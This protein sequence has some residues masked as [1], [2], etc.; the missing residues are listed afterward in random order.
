VLRDKTHSTSFRHTQRRHQQQKG[1]LVFTDIDKHAHTFFRLTRP[2]GDEH[3]HT[4]SRNHT[5]ARMHA[6]ADARRHIPRSMACSLVVAVGVASPSVDAAEFCFG[7]EPSGADG[8]GERIVEAGIGAL[9][10]ARAAA[11]SGVGGMTSMAGGGV[12]AD[13]AVLAGGD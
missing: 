3:I 8:G 2:C 12:G 4:S 11:V 13:D 7:R 10:C 9:A 1:P 6:H 5:H